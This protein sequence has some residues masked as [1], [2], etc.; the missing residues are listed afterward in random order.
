VNQ[1]VICISMPP[2]SGP[3]LNHP[4]ALNQA[5]PDQEPPG[6]IR[7][8]RIDVLYVDAIYVNTARIAPSPRPAH[9][10]TMACHAKQSV[11]GNENAVCEGY[12]PVRQVSFSPVHYLANKGRGLCPESLPVRQQNL[13]GWVVI[14]KHDTSF[15]ETYEGWGVTMWAFHPFHPF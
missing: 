7:I 9:S 5:L 11:A 1:N 10:V 14:V 8:D 12:E 15:P 2:S 3:T 4:Q 13:G 6:V